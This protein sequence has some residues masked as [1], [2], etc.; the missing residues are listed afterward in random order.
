MLTDNQ[1]VNLITS[2]NK[3]KAK[4]CPG[5]DDQHHGRGV[6]SRS[7][8]CTGEKLLR[9]F[10]REN[11]CRAYEGKRPPGNR[12]SRL[13]AGSANPYPRTQCR[14][15]LLL[16]ECTFLQLIGRSK[17]GKRGPVQLSCCF[18]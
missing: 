8:R 11:Q 9:A 13:Q 2:T 7:D 16:E 17:T 14:L 1:H 15:S 3:E 5:R 10:R 6:C 4:N 12:W 18:H